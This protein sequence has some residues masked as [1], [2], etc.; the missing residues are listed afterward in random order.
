[1]QTVWVHVVPALMYR[2]SFIVIFLIICIDI[3]IAAWLAEGTNE[4]MEDRL[5]WIR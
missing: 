3:V 5:G 1:M 4:W 2:N